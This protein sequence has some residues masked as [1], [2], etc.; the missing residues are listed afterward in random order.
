[1]TANEKENQ[2]MSQQGI[3]KIILLGYAGNDAELKFTASGKAVANFSVAVNESYKNSIG[4]N[5]DRVE[6]FRCV[7]WNGLAELCGQYILRG[8]H[9]SQAFD[10][11][12]YRKQEFIE[13]K[14]AGRP[15]GWSTTQF[16]FT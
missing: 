11:I 8:R 15:D 10:K 9:L 3:N 1:V 13:S 12:F 2:P 4:D 7:A 6:W 16:S 14:E 5:V